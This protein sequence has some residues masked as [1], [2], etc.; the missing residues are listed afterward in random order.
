MVML[1]YDYKVHNQLSKL[2]D[3]I[4][5]SYRLRKV[6]YYVNN[7]LVCV[8]ILFIVSSF[9]SLITKSEVAV[10]FGIF[11]FI[12][13]AIGFWSLGAFPKKPQIVSLDVLEDKEYILYLRAFSEDEKTLKN[14]AMPYCGEF[15]GFTEDAFLCFFKNAVA[16]GQPGELFPPTASHRIY[17]KEEDWKKSVLKMIKESRLIILLVNSNMN[18]VWEISNIKNYKKKTV[19]IVD[20]IEE[21]NIAKSMMSENNI[22]PTFTNIRTPFCFYFDENER[23]N[24]IKFDNDKLSYTMVA[25]TILQHFKM[26]A[27]DK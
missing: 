4:L 22:L 12:Y 1:I 3:D 24:T 19:F 23:I 6:S 13:M 26:E 5:V 16:V 18:C 17:F 2:K 9:S 25:N 7:V 27:K 21:Y 10:W 15:R 11:L 14:K 8:F 20:N